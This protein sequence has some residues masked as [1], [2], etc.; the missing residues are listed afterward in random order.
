MIPL[1]VRWI[2]RRGSGGGAFKFF[3]PVLQE[4]NADGANKQ[5]A[6]APALRDVSAQLSSVHP[7]LSSEISVSAKIVQDQDQHDG[8]GAGHPAHSP[9]EGCHAGSNF[10][11][12][13]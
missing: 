9:V 5:R 12:M 1:D 8:H 3:E 10:Q 7:F 13:N 2:R 4:I 6:K 11:V